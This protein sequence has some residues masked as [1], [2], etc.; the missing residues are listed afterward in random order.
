MDAATSLYA[1]LGAAVVRAGVGAVWLDG[2]G[3]G[4]DVGGRQ[5]V[6]VSG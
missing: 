2:G 3:F 4:G 5:V 6:R 1:L